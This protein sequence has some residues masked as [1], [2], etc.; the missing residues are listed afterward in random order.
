MIKLLPAPDTDVVALRVEGDADRPS[1]QAVAQ[2]MEGLLQQCDRLKLYAELDDV[3]DVPS[4]V[5]LDDLRFGMR[6][7][8]CF[9][10]IAVV[11]ETPWPPMGAVG[12]ATI[13]PGA[14]VRH[15]RF[16]QRTDALRWLLSE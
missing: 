7:R 2:S 1:L 12:E 8:D 3:G 11:S 16:G 13:W 10:R 15:F 4:D 5:I 6:H 14:A 9:R